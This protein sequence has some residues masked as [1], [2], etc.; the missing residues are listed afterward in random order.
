MRGYV[1]R[2]DIIIGYTAYLTNESYLFWQLANQFS[3]SSRRELESASDQPN[4]P[5]YYLA[6]HSI[7][8]S[9][10]CF[11]HSTGYSLD[12]LKSWDFGHN[13]EALL[14]ASKNEGIG[15]HV[16]LSFHDELNIERLNSH[17]LEKE[18]EYLEPQIYTLPEIGNIVGV[19]ESLVSSLA[20]HAAKH[21][22]SDDT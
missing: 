2:F 1:E 11:L 4:I 17:Y 16:N 22:D 20:E 3:R 12:E 6:G 10:K 19:A 15:Q 13:L 8:L 21:S 18:L 14:E 9:L 7:E 5:C